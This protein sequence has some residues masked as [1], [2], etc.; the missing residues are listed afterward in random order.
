MASKCERGFSS[1]DY[2]WPQYLVI[3]CKNFRVLLL[4]NGTCDIFIL[5]N[6]FTTQP[7]LLLFIA[8]AVVAEADL[9]MVE[10]KKATYEFDRDIV[11]GA[12]NPVRQN[13][14]V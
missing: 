10:M 11:R 6:S 4:T 3:V 9:R 8:Q 13:L 5:R 1:L 2:A 12:V 14:A 7:C